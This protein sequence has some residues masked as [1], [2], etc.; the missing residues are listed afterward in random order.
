MKSFPVLLALAV[1]ALLLASCGGHEAY[2]FPSSA[3]QPQTITL[4]DTRTGE[5]VWSQEVPV[6]KQLNMRFMRRGDIA[7]GQGW[8]EMRW[9]IS[10][11]GRDQSGTPS[12]MRVPP[13]S[14]RRIETHVRTTPESRP[15]PPTPAPVPVMAA[16][17]PAPKPAPARPARSTSG[18]VMPDPKQPA[19]K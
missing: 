15:E 8:D 17:A 4:V 6:G 7:D 9:S 13:P 16:P 3:H 1:P 19:P 5:S 12:T 14:E 2:H 18:L 11:V 10:D